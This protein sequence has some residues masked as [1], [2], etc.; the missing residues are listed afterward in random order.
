VF[1]VEVIILTTE[2][3]HL[4]LLVEIRLQ[5]ETNHLVVVLKGKKIESL[6]MENQ[7]QEEELDEEADK[8]KNEEDP[9]KDVKPEN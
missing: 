6:D 8:Q 9:L 3:N 1:N 5:E 7:I 2:I 4:F